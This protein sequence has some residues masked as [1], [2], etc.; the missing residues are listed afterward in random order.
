MHSSK[1]V[2]IVF[3]FRQ[4]A[5]ADLAVETTELQQ[6]GYVLGIKFSEFLWLN[7]TKTFS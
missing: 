4:L 1:F 2:A 6:F 5:R 3:D 7:L